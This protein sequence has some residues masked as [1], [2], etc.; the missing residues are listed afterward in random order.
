MLG[1]LG[2]VFVKQARG[3]V[4][5]NKNGIS[6]LPGQV[7]GTQTYRKE[8]DTSA[9]DGDFNI[10]MPEITPPCIHIQSESSSFQLPAGF[11]VSCPL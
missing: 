2:A 4:N 9:A 7:V 11:C 1:T 10:H 6:K 5:N 3:D 8:F